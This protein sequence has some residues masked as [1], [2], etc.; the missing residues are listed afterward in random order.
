MSWTQVRWAITG[1]AIGLLIAVVPSC[2]PKPCGPDNC[3]LGC[4]NDKGA[5]VGGGEVAACGASGVVCSAC[6]ANQLCTAG[7]CKDTGTNPD[8]GTDGGVKDGGVPDAGQPCAKDDD[9]S[10]Y[11]NGSFCNQL[12]GQCMPG[13]ACN[14][15]SDCSSLEPLDP[16]YQY[17]LQ[18]RCVVESGAQPGFAGVCRRRLAPC[19]ECTDSS[20]CGNDFLFDPQGT[21]KGL[22]G[23]SSGKKY[24]FQQKV[25]ACPCGTVD[26]GVGFCKPQSN[27]CSSVGCAEDKSCPSGSVCNKG[28]CLCEPRCRW[29]F[30]KKELAAPGCPPGKTCWVD[31]ANLNANSLFYGAGRC[32]APCTSETEC[33]K[34]STNAFG[35]DRLTCRGE[36][37]N[38]GG[39]SD[40]R[41]RANGDCMD[42]Q[43]CPEQPLE[44]IPLG[45]C[46]RGSFTCN[47]DCR[48]GTDPVTSLGYKDCRSPFTCATDG[49]SKDAGA[50][51]CR[52][53]TCVEQ[54][55]ASIACTRGE[56][57]CGEDKNNDGTPDPCPPASERGPDNCYTAPKPPFCTTCMSNDDCKNLQLPAYLQ[58]AGACT[59]LSKSPSCSPMPMLCLQAS[60]NTS[61]CTPSTFNDGTKDS[62]GVGRD[63]RGCPA[64]Y[65]AVIIRPKLAQGDDYCNTNADCSQGNDGGLCQT[66]LAITFQDGGHPKTCQCTVGAP[67][68]CPNND[69]GLTSECKFGIS[70]QTLP[71]VQSVVCAPNAAI[72]FADAGPPRFG[73]GLTP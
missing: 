44:S 62:F 19:E 53:L 50:N 37:L 3:T 48:L 71:C 5:C 49:G 39:T 2:T 41:C 69:A 70:G 25:G 30:V 13:T 58:G 36:A 68:A 31:D 60:D 4:C 11:K 65:P 17:G 43:E 14:V 55:G 59:N 64:G 40:K 56:Y 57:C 42:N 22:Q 12:T 63:S 16:C 32:R 66:E 72:L 21:C 26:D 73:C 18:C 7:A 46:D 54:G 23:D 24:C 15:S 20:Q 52:L 35:G 1:M 61:V 45:Y 8:G 47:T 6:T 38:G 33:K 34:S 10:V 27:S 28:A 29:D 51:F 9:C 67:N